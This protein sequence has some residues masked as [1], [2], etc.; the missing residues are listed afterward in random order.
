MHKI[1]NAYG[2][3]GGEWEK[4]VGATPYE[5]RLQYLRLV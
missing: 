1:E 5:G 2:Y 4:D 3:V